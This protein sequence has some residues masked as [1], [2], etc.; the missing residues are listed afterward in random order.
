MAVVIACKPMAA[1]YECGGQLT[2]L[3]EQSRKFGLFYSTMK[4]RSCN[5]QQIPW[6]MRGAMKNKQVKA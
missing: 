6:P 2:A 3:S 4:A 5:I 1:N